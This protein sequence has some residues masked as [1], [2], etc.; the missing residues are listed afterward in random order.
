MLYCLFHNRVVL[1]NQKPFYLDCKIIGYY[2]SLNKALCEKEKYAKIKGFSSYA[3]GFGIELVLP[4]ENGSPIVFNQTNFVYRIGYASINRTSCLEFNIDGYYLSKEAAN[5]AI[6][7]LRR[8][9]I[10][11]KAADNLEVY[12][13]LIDHSFWV[14]GFDIS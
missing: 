9:S 1:Q 7:K 3:E 8:C 6:D 11:K 10:F 2:S 14:D 4:C 12:E 5:S 13:L